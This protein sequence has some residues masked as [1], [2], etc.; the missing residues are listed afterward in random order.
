MNKNIEHN[1]L[2]RDRIPEIIK[3]AGKTPIYKTLTSDEYEIELSNKLQEELD[4]YKNDLN[5]EE[6]ADLQEVIDCILMHKNISKDEF[7][8]IVNNKKDKRGSFVD[9]LYLERVIES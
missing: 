4:E 5:L 1:K 7:Y 8:K 9:R 6:L 3:E 2:V